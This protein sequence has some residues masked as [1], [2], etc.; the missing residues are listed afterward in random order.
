MEREEKW[1]KKELTSPL[2]SLGITLLGEKPAPS[3]SQGLWSTMSCNTHFT[4]PSLLLDTPIVQI[5]ALRGYLKHAVWRFNSW[6]YLLHG[7]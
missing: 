1:G 4:F 6:L 7:C 3:P 5:A 2:A